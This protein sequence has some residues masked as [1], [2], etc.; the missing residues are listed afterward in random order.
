[1]R[2]E[3]GSVALVAEGNHA[4]IDSLASLALLIGVIGV[5]AACPLVDPLIG[6]SIAVLVLRVA[7]IAGAAVPSRFLDRIDPEETQAIT[8]IAASV[9]G[10]LKVAE[11][12]ARWVGHR[13][14]AEVAVV[15]DPE[16]SLLEG[17]AVGEAVRDALGRGV[18]YLSRVTVSTKPASRG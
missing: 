13:I 5:A 2:N 7:W 9:D 12:R 16:L 11:V 1:M 10:V 15:V 8:Q 18:L 6:L 17:H 14:E 4:R 3:I